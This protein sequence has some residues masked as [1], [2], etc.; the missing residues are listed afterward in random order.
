M[1]VMFIGIS[2]F[3]YLIFTTQNNHIG[4]CVP[5]HT[6]NYFVSFFLMEKDILEEQ[7][8]V[9]FYASLF[10]HLYIRSLAKQ[11]LALELGV[12]PEDMSQQ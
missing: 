3:K 1:I 6:A 10:S 9:I 4:V 8:K 12:W 5:S 2:H 7:I 11:Y